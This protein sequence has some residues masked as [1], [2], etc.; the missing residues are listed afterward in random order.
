MKIPQG[1]KAM[2]LACVVITA[3]LLTAGPLSASTI[4]WTDWTSFSPGNPGSASGT[5]TAGVT[6]SYGGELENLFYNYPSWGPPGTFNGGTVGNAPPSPNGIIQLYGGAPSTGLDTITFSHAVVNPVFAIWSLGSGGSSATFVFNQTPTLESGGPS[7]EYGG[8]SI[9]VSGNTV[10]GN[11]GN[12]TVEFTGT[13][14]SIS[15]TNP[16]FENWYGFTVGISGVAAS[17]PEPGTTPLLLFGLALL[18][19]AAAR[20]KQHLANR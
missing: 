15:W 17:T 16:Q 7:N 19:M 13:F 18:G 4:D 20:R 11:E 1:S 12:G 5:T 8:S 2:T 14:N 10:S 9:T 3:C 6:V